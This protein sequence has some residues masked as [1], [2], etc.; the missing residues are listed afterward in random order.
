[1]TFYNKELFL[2]VSM[3]S[4]KAFIYLIL[5]LA[6][7]FWSFSYIWTANVFKYLNPISTVFTRLVIGSF[8]LIGMS[9]IMKKLQRIQTKD[10]PRFLLL[11]FFEPLLYYLGES[12]GLKFVSP[13]VAAI[14][15]STIPLFVPFS[16]YFLANEPI[17]SGTFFGILIAFIG[18]L[19][20]VLN[21]D[22][23]FA[24]SPKGLGFL[25]IAV[26]SVMGYSYLLQGLTKTY[27]AYTIISAQ[28]FIGIFYFLPLLLL[29]DLDVMKTVTINSELVINITALAIFASSLAFFLFTIGTKHIGV[30]KASIFTYLV[31]VFTAS[32]SYFTGH[33]KFTTL[34]IIGMLVVITGL[35]LS[36]IQFRKYL[37]NMLKSDER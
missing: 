2:P 24:A 15:I 29:F 20:V 35:S 12:Y 10:I 1:M 16:M 17:K 34:R 36:Q 28:N 5:L 23:S 21:K 3:K 31:P 27:N 14:V 7:L 19:M 32:I 13:T 30:T 26:A 18:V 25:M 4:G 22:L 8:F 6:M 37:N 33:E 11:A 9:L